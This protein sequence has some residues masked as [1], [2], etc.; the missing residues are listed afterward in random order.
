MRKV[1]ECNRRNPENSLPFIPSDEPWTWTPRNDDTD[2]NR[3]AYPDANA[4]RRHPQGSWN[5][6][7]EIAHRNPGAQAP[8]SWEDTWTGNNY[9]DFYV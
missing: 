8:K 2:K 9:E 1:E 4:N 7:P 3:Q 5:R 6:E